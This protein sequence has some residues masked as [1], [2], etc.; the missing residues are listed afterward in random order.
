MQFAENQLNFMVQQD[1]GKKERKVRGDVM[2][3]I[4]KMMVKGK[5]RYYIILKNGRYRFVKAPNK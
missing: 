5:P 4:H 1:T 3:K 2:P